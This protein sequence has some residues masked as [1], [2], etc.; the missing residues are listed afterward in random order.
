VTGQSYRD[1]IAAARAEGWH[2]AGL[3]ATSDGA[4]VRTLL[5]DPTGATRLQTVAVH[6]GTVPS[7]VDLFPAAGWDE[8]E[9][10]A[11][12]GVDFVGHEPLRPL[13]DHDL[14]LDH[15]TVPVR[16]HDA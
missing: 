12:Q 10:H 14:R 13:V 3:H 15:W 4:R 16:G 2:F 8:R 9:A 6:G 11:P 7:I 5:A 1:E